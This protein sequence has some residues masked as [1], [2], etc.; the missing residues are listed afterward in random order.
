[1]FVYYDTLLEV[2]RLIQKGTA[3]SCVV[4]SLKRNVVIKKIIELL[5]I[6]EENMIISFSFL[7]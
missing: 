6:F 2:I 1:M 7:N 3:R 4:P 5:Q